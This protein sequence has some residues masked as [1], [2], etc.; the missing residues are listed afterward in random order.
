MSS[1]TEIIAVLEYM[2]KEKGIARGDMIGA[3]QEAI[4]SAALKSIHF[5]HDVRVHIHPKTGHLQ[6]W[7]VY[8]VVDSV[9]DPAA[10]MHLLKARELDP[11][12]QL[13]GTVEKEIPP[14][15][16]GRIAAQSTRQAINQS[17]RH[18]EKGRIY[19]DF[20]NQVGKF[21]TG[22]VRA[23]DRGHLF[24]DLGKAEGIMPYR[25]RTPGEDYRPGDPVRCLLLRIESTPNGPEI[26]LS[27]SCDPFIHKL[28]ELEIS[29]IADGT[30]AVHSL[31]RE[32]GYRTKVAV[33]SRELNVDP[34][35]ACIGARGVR[36]RSICKELGNEKI[37][38]LR[39]YPDPVEF[40]IEAIRPAIPRN[41]Q[42]D[43]RDRRLTFE[44]NEEDLA[45]AIG[46]RGLNAKLT[47]KLMN[48]K[49][50]INR[51]APQ[52]D[53]ALSQR[54]QKATEGLNGIPGISDEMAQK[55]VAIGI[56]GLDVFEGV[57]AEDLQSSGFGSEEAESILS[58]V[59]AFRSRT[60]V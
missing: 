50:S 35:G 55:L 5:G 10:Q 11:R 22:I 60:A 16:L 39:Y 20:R 6:A 40:L 56:T 18:F 1:G 8:E 59:Q 24:I 4:R 44:V 17:V 37:D 7:A 28:L 26:I 36:I 33:E 47:S 49:L 57:T 2:E 58:S 53:V 32:A 42:I 31:A 48:W 38:I 14:S 43:E 54:I 9:A 25:E 30:I 41:I 13:G 12:A 51:T 45:I 29:E 52:A 46:K 3:I 15:A 19:E 27:R 34:V 21:V 23:E